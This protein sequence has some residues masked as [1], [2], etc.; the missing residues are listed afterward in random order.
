MFSARYLS[1]DVNTDIDVRW[2]WHAMVN[3]RQELVDAYECTD[4]LPISASPLYDPS[5]WRLNRDPRLLLT[6]KGFDDTVIN[7]AGQEMGFSYN[8]ISGTGYEPVKYCNWDVLPIDY[9]TRSE[10]DWV[11]IRYADVLLMYA[12]ARNEASGPDASIYSAVNQVR[13][14]V[15]MPPIP[16]GLTKDELRERIRHERRVEFALEGLYWSDILRWRTAEHV[17]P[18]IVDPGGVRRTFDPGKHYLLPF[19][20]SEIDVN[21]NLEQNPGY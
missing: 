21:E 3:P 8:A 9:S 1:P 13:A 11:L 14:R 4:G 5:N 10:Q 18:T 6:I 20:Q 17:I 12:E 2:A 19:P 15:D 16:E 7:S